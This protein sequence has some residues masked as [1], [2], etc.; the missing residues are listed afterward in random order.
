MSPA[1]CFVDA[2]H[3]DEGVVRDA[4]FCR[5]LLAGG[6]LAF[7][8]AGTGYRGLGR[9]LDDSAGRHRAPRLLPP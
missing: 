4:H 8:D 3:T 7:H 2:E 9:F 1:L 5:R 6:W